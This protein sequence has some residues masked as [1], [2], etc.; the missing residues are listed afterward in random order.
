MSTIAVNS[1]KG[2]EV[3]QIKNA[4]SVNNAEFQVQDSILDK[5]LAA[6][7]I[8]V[9]QDLVDKEVNLMVLEFNHQLKYESLATGRMP[10]LAKD[11]RV[12]RLEEIKAE[13]FH[14]VKT[15]LVLQGIIEA[16]DL[17]VSRCELEE[18]AQAIA[19]REGISIEMVKSFLGEDLGMLK[20][21]LLIM[22]AIDYLAANAVIK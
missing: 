12:E 2:I 6:A 11:E 15:R 20:G 8:E 22:K 17:E 9:P 7:D 21:D 5:I 13:A 16:E 1:D 19:R 10:G 14:L 3:E 18:E 4:P